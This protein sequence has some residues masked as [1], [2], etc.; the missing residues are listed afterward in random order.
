MTTDNNYL[1]QLLFEAKDTCQGTMDKLSQS[2][3]TQQ[4]ELK[5]IQ[6]MIDEVFEK[7]RVDGIWT[8]P[9]PFDE[10]RMLQFILSIHT[11]DEEMELLQEFKSRVMAFKRYL[12][13]E[14]LPKPLGTL[15]ES[16]PS[17]WN[18]KMLEALRLLR[19]VITRK[20]TALTNAGHNPMDDDDFNEQD[21]HFATAVELYRDHLKENLVNT[22]EGDLKTINIVSG[23]INGVTE[24]DKFT[25]F[26]K[27]LNQFIDKKNNLA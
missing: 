9:I 14:V 1:K 10:A 6:A 16:A 11:L 26:Y 25:Q 3:Q 13:T 4:A 24:V 5:K 20:K 27:L 15:M 19:G 12:E 23:L 18:L 7:F 8:Q 22:H 17:D 21:S 2:E